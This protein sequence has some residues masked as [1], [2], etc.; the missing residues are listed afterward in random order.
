VIYYRLMADVGPT[1]T[2]TVTFL[3]PI[4]G[5]VWGA[6]FLNERITGTTLIGG[7]LI[8][9]GTLLTTAPSPPRAAEPRTA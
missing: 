5:V 8:L 4:F 1:R 9:T 2:L 6:V 7:A 3:V